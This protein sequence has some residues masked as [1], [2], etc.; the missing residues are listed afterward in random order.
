MVFLAKK[1]NKRYASRFLF[2]ILLYI[3]F[4]LAFSS[5]ISEISESKQYDMENEKKNISKRPEGATS[6]PIKRKLFERFRKEVTIDKY[7]TR[8]GKKVKVVLV[9]KRRPIFDWF[10]RWKNKRKIKKKAKKEYKINRDQKNKKPNMLKRL[11][12]KKKPNDESN[13][14][15]LSNVN[16]E[17]EDEVSVSKSDIFEEDTGYE[18]NKSKKGEPKIQKSE[19]QLDNTIDSPS[20]TSNFD[21]STITGENTDPSDMKTS[22]YN[23]DVSIL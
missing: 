3:V 17:K 10:R 1:P 4:K 20:G 14:H 8:D 23:Y 22:N 9:R 11:F 16:A 19:I 18:V 21:K 13:G 12:R 5:E 6:I 15:N 2:I 7:Y